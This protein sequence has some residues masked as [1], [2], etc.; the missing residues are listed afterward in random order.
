MSIYFRYFVVLLFVLI[1]GNPFL[2]QQVEAGIIILCICSLF[3]IRR[4]Y[5]KQMQNDQ[6]SFLLILFFISFELIHGLVFGLSNEKTIFRV[7][8]Y[9]FISLVFSRLFVF[10]FIRIYVNLIIGLVLFS[11]IFYLCAYLTPNIYFYL[12]NLSAIVF[13][14]R[15]NYADYSTPT[16][17]LYTFDTGFISGE[18]DILRNPGFTWEAG[19]FA[20]FINIAIFFELINTQA[21]SLFPFL[22]RKR[23]IILFLGLISTFS[24]AGFISLFVLI[25]FYFV[26]Y[27]NINNVISS[28]VVLLL[29]ILL[30][31]QLDFLSQKINDQ[32]DI[33]DFSQNRFSA[34]LLDFD[35]FIRSPFI[36]WSRDLSVLF[37]TSVYTD[38]THRP[39]GVTNFLRSYGF[40]Y[41][42]VYFVS[43]FSSLK[44]YFAHMGYRRAG[45]S[46]LILILSIIIMGFAQ[47]VIHIP[48]IMF[49]LFLG[50]S[51]RSLN[52]V[53]K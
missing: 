6:K 7:F 21:K 15:M 44:I 18:G 19:G 10:D 43:L 40:I 24:T 1:N 39:N 47:Q 29:S 30:Y 52:S 13:P 5:I 42:L 16:M 26:T 11:F 31:Y 37:K 20:F 23:S 25:F 28:A 49:L 36:G 34:A 22:T 12:N 33:S 45:R 50:N 27:L 2:Q 35:D 48:F 17:I 32:L 53:Y 38:F 46:S 4:D 3:L 8:S 51:A 41:F 9:F 14:L